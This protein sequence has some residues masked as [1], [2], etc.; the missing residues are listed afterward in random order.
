MVISALRTTP[1]G[2]GVGP[3]I[4]ASQAQTGRSTVI[5]NPSGM[6]IRPEFA[7]TSTIYYQMAL[8]HSPCR[9]S[10]QWKVPGEATGTQ[11]AWL[12][13]ISAGI[14]LETHCRAPQ[15]AVLGPVCDKV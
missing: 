13:W 6:P 8:A 4:T 5:G 10:G 11:D 12:S 2:G 3:T 1:S 9:L 14:G 7:R 15:H